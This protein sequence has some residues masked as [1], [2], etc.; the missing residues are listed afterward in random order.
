VSHL[1]PTQSN[2]NHKR[3][4]VI[5]ISFKP[6]VDPYSQIM[7]KRYAISKKHTKTAHEEYGLFIKNIQ[8]AN[9]YKR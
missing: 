3:V 2:K 7:S 4:N 8:R 5:N 9:F 1:L 6:N